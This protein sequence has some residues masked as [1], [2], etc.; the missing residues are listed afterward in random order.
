MD[1]RRENAF[2]EAK[3]LEKWRKRKADEYKH[4]QAQEKKLFI[5]ELDRQKSIFSAVERN[6]IEQNIKE[7]NDSGLLEAAC[8]R[9]LGKLH[10]RIKNSKASLPSSAPLHGLF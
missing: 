3:G 1:R 9:G 6:Y 7:Y 2:R 4:K 5:E 10:R 8:W